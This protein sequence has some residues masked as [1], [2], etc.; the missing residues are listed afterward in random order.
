MAKVWYKYFKTSLTFEKTKC[1]HKIYKNISKRLLSKKES[2]ENK[3]A[4]K[5]LA[6]IRWV[7]SYRFNHERAFLKTSKKSMDAL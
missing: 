1:S 6:L 5:S 2:F 7:S 3:N 4:L